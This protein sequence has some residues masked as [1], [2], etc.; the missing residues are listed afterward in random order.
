MVKKINKDRITIKSLVIHWVKKGQIVKML[1]PS[2]QNPL[3][4]EY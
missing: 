2:K 4:D 1:R 3:L